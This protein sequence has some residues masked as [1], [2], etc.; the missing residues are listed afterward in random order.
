MTKPSAV[1]ERAVFLCPEPPYPLAGGGPMRSASLL[2]FLADRLAV[3][4]ITFRDGDSSD[5]T[6]FLNPGLAETVTCVSLPHQ[7]KKAFSR[8]YR[9]TAR[10]LRGQ[11]P[12]TDRFGQAQALGRVEAATRNQSYSLAVI[13]HFWCAPY[14]DVLRPRAR[15]VVLDLHNIESALHAAC[16]TSEPWPQRVGHR[17]F[18]RT[19][20]RMEG[21]ILADFDLVL[22]ASEA[23]RGRVLEIAPAANVAVYPNSIPWTPQP[24]V[25]EEDV[26]AFSGNMEYHPNVTAV[27]HFR[28][29]VWPL[30]ESKAPSLRWRLIG[31]NEFAVR[32]LVADDPRIDLTGPVADAVGELARAKVVVVPLLAGSGTRVKILEAWAA[33]R[34]VVST[35]IGADGLAVRNGENIRIADG[36]GEMAAAVL[37]LLNDEVSRKRMG[38][39]GRKTYEAGFGWPAAWETF[40]PHFHKLMSREE[41][42]TAI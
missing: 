39:Q 28:R 25:E 18:E 8:M 19:A 15:R 33:G 4:L 7:D 34:A 16:S 32:S 31:K 9:N 40:E 17:F 20:R 23:D 21:A 2:H 10:L 3:H 37:E 1:S 22:V 6:P 41:V 38:E 11:L 30:I 42:L 13:E 5:P 12:L 24:V 26:I 36:P 14:L 27:R 29:R 35:T